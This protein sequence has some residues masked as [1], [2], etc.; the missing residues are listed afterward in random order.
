MKKIINILSIIV[1]V[2]LTFTIKDVF[3]DN[4][5]I[6]ELIPHDKKVTI[7]GDIFLYKN[8]EFKNARI[9]IGQIKNISDE[10]KKITIS[11]AFFDKDKNNITII[12]YCSSNEVLAPKGTKDNYEISIDVSKLA[13]NKKIKDIKYY[14]I[15]SENKSCRLGGEKEYTGR[16]IS[17]INRLGNSELPTGAKLLLNVIKVVVGL[18]VVLF[19]YKLL[20]TSS[21]DNMNGDDVRNAFKYINKE[22]AKERNKKTFINKDI[23]E[24]KKPAKSEKILAQEEK[25]NNK[26]KKGDSDL[27]NMYK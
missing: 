17:E 19:L 5:K 14:A 16:K 2:I 6:M 24:D 21:Y 18:L 4:Y 22:K 8:I 27:Q 12:N 9:N 13:E 20:F 23:K 15:I 1:I 10:D 3:A 7:R 26:E 25:E 11:L